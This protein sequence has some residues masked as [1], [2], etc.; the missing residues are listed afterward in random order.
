MRLLQR[1][2]SD[3]MGWGWAVINVVITIML[4]VNRSAGARMSVLYSN[5]FKMSAPQPASSAPSV[6]AAGGRTI[7]RN[8]T[9]DQELALATEVVDGEIWIEV[10]IFANARSTTLGVY[11]FHRYKA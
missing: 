8:F 1:G 9:L 2:R 6:A 3:H 10:S 11:A 5:R 4:E 7:L